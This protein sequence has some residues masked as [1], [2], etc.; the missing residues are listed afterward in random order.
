[1]AY[2]YSSHISPIIENGIK[3][4]NIKIFIFIIGERGRKTKCVSVECA[5]ASERNITVSLF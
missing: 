4:I 5:R 1:M 3:T 2:E